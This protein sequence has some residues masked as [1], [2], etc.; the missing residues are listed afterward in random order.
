MNTL[1]KAIHKRLREKNLTK[2][3]KVKYKHYFGCKICD[4][5]KAW[6]PHICCKNCYTGLTYWL[7]G[8]QK[9]I[10]FALQE[11]W[12]EPTNH[13]NNCYFCLIKVSRYSKSTK[14]RIVYPECPSALRPVTHLHENIPIPST[15]P[16]SELKN[17]K[18]SAKSIYIFLNIK[19][20]CK[21][22]VN[23]RR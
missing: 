6:A 16:V 13:A 18:S 10:L 22:C 20:I 4:K 9:S 5:D 23:V 3:V 11:I 8:K 17:D 21:H 7:N 15:S 19:V 2:S 12:C 1:L 14:S